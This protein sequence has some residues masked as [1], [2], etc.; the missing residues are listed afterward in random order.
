MKLTGEWRAFH[1]HLIMN[2]GVDVTGDILTKAQRDAS[3]CTVKKRYVI[4]REA[5]E[6]LKAY[7]SLYTAA[8]RPSGAFPKTMR[9]PTIE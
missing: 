4:M 8:M 6:T 2:K 1:E 5:M 3:D 7:P 9:I